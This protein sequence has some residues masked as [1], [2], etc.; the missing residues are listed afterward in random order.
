MDSDKLRIAEG[1]YADVSKASKVGVASREDLIELLKSGEVVVIDR[2]TGR[3]LTEVMGVAL[4]SGEKVLQAA[5]SKGASK[6][7]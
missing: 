2:K 1:V 4:P 6:I 7:I 3:A 5:L